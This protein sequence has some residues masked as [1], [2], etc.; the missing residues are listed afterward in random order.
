MTVSGAIDGTTSQNFGAGDYFELRAG[1]GYIS[2][3]NRSV[4]PLVSSQAANALLAGPSSG[5]AAA[6]GFRALAAADLPPGTGTVTSVGL[7]LPSVFAVTGS[8]VTGSGTLTATAAS[9]AANQVWAGPAS[10]PAA[11]PGFRAL[12]AADLPA[13]PMSGLS[14]TL[15]VSQGGTGSSSLSPY[16]VLCGGATGI[17]AVQE[18]SGTGTSGQVL[19]SNGAAL[20]L[21]PGAFGRD[22][23]GVVAAVGL[24][25]DRLAG[26]RLGDADGDGGLPGGQPGLGRTGLGAGGGAELPRPGGGR[27]A[28]GHGDGDGHLG[29]AVAAV[30]LRGDR[31]AGDRL[32]DAD[33]HGDGPGGQPGLG[34]PELGAGGG[35]RLP[36]PGGGRPAGD[37]DVGPVGD[38][39]RL[40][41]RDGLLEPVAVCGPLRGRHGDRCGP[42]GLR[43]GDLGPGAHVQRRGGA[44]LVQGTLGRDLGRPDDAGE[45][46]G[47]R[48]AGDRLGDAGRDEHHAGGPDLHVLGHVHGA[49]GGLIRA[50]HRRR[51]GGRRR[52]R[53]LRGER[54]GGLRRR[55]RGLGRDR[56]RDLSGLGAGVHAGGH[57]RRGGAGG[58]AA[59][60]SPAAGAVNSGGAGVGGAVPSFSY[61]TSS[62][63]DIVFANGGA[64]GAGGGPSNPGTAPGGNSLYPGNYGGEGSVTAAAQGGAQGQINGGGGGGGGG[65]SAGGTAYAGG[66]GGRMPNGFQGFNAN[67]AGGPAGTSGGNG[68]AG[69]ASP[70]GSPYGGGGGS[71]GGAA[72]S[73]SGAAGNGAAGGNYGAGGGGGGAGPSG[74]TC[75]TGGAA[76]AASS[77]STHG[78]FGF[79]CSVFGVRCSVFSKSL[80]AR[81]LN[82]T[83]K[84]EH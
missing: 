22:L 24:R 42:G 38:A 77:S 46:R 14:G 28:P 17:G 4:A 58:T 70:P 64:G 35:A 79:Q 72:G 62:G 82:W 12:A 5:P 8:P 78:N 61:V 25:G 19:T 1:A 55:R 54:P 10:G 50:D 36:R 7:S 43:H 74:A 80:R 18:V 59:S 66:T 48:L 44:A 52:G 34:R 29:R 53:R 40:P 76:P 69:T 65:L 9:Q 45:F 56:R 71:G 6:P 63:S 32:G 39:G 41:G 27:P 47:D 57:R 60:N 68:A 3:L 11:A 81:R 15:G 83:R 23:G 51:R 73:G 33:G 20:P 2:D 21:V 67:A 16:A 13:I 31:L 37:P 49:G 26:D 84:T 75:S 30:G